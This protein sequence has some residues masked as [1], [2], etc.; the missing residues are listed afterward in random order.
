MN[1]CSHQL[2]QL[3]CKNIKA[4]IPK[5]ISEYGFVSADNLVFAEMLCIHIIIFDEYQPLE[6][7][8]ES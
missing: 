6:A 7:S 2:L 5:T 3:V 4:E 8:I 1:R